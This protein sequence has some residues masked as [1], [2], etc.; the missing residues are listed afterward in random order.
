MSVSAP[1]VV[2]TRPEGEQGPLTGQLRR[3][4]LTVLLWPTVSYAPS[5]S[6]DLAQALA[7]VHDFDWIV[8]A[9]RQAV[10]AVLAYLPDAPP[11]VRVCAVGAS[12]AQAL[13]DAGWPIDMVPADS[14]AAGVV[15]AYA[16]LYG[17]P[18]RV[19][20]PAS[21][22]ALPIIAA[23]LTKLGTHI[24]QVEAYQTLPAAL[25]AGSTHEWIARRGVA[26]VTF[27]SPSAVTELVRALGKEDF[28]GLLKAAVPV[29]IGRSTAAV[30]KDLGH[31]SVLP[32][33]ATLESLALATYLSLQTKH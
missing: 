24:T 22:R 13:S 21:S 1:V 14:S 8:F 7:R 12:T 30:L 25:D 19:L 18:G 16:S 31:E 28:D 4:G 5:A 29:A 33:H 20:Y 9:S 32:E 10:R 3:L 6:P 11:G 2:V 17:P 26:A 27:A 23:G 15:A